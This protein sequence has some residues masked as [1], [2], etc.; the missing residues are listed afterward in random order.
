MRVAAA[1]LAMLCAAALPA[2]AA[3]RFFPIEVHLDSSAPVAAWQFELADRSGAITVVGVEGGGSAAFRRAPYYDRDAVAAG[4]AKRIVVADFSVADEGQ[5]PSGP[6]R[7]ATLHLMAEGETD[8]DLDSMETT[9]RL[10]GEE[11]IRFP[12]NDMVFGVETYISAMSR[13]LTLYPGDVIWM[14]TD[15]SSKNLIDGDVVEIEISGVG[16]L[17]NPVV[18]G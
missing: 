15:G 11:Q 5:L 12:T 14:G 2:S 13:Y 3:P 10:N 7:L 1:I 18:R 16:A 8:A 4:A 17:T 6:I 9:V